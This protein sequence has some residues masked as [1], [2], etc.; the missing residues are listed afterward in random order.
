[1]NKQDRAPAPGN[2]RPQQLRKKGKRAPN[3][4][5]SGGRR[6][7]SVIQSDRI[8]QTVSVPA[9]R[10]VIRKDTAPNIKSVAKGGCR[11][12]HS[13]FFHDVLGT[14]SGHFI[15]HVISPT[16]AGVFPWLNTMA[17]N[18]ESYQ[19]NSLR[20]QYSNTVG[21]AHGGTV[22]IAMDYDSN[23]AFPTTKGQILTYDDRAHCASYESC[24]SVCSQHNL[25]KR[26]SL[27]TGD[28]P[29]GKDPNLY[30]VGNLF[31]YTGNNIDTR[32]VGEL[33]VEYDVTFSTPQAAVV[34]FPDGIGGSFFG[35][36]N[37]APLG[38]IGDT[39]ND[40]LISS[41]TM[42]MPVSTGSGISVTTFTFNKFWSGFYSSSF[43]GTNLTSIG[44]G[45]TCSRFHV[46]PEIGF[47]TQIANC[48]KIKAEAGETLVLTIGN[49]SI[50]RADICFGQSPNALA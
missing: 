14:I 32:Q 16:N 46:W 22:V 35:T 33:Y 31:L 27:Y 20:F 41:G 2:N 39:T 40:N 15:K 19:F 29:A 21:T 50:T 24:T 36:T 3:P 9:V 23:D 28:V 48:Q 7:Y 17:K 45:G 38:N 1:M 25:R 5:K 13:E 47:A 6:A 4:K 44:E 30:N 34:P 12:V 10:S 37:V 26:A 43:S 42:A 8:G 11:I 18:Y 49:D